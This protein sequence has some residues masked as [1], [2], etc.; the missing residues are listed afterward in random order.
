M[1]KKDYVD[2]YYNMACLYA[3]QDNKVESIQ[4]LKAAIAVNREVI[5]WAKNDVDLKSVSAS[6]EFRKLVENKGD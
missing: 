3:R 1:D 5:G 2:P 4:Y 6:E